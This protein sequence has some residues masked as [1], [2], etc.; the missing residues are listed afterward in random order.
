MTKRYPSH[1]TPSLTTE[2]P[3][4]HNRFLFSSTNPNET[5]RVPHL[6]HSTSFCTTE[7]TPLFVTVN[8]HYPQCN[9]VWMDWKCYSRTLIPGLLHCSYNSIYPEQ[10]EY[11]LE[12]K[13]LFETNEHKGHALIEMPTGTGKT[14]CIFSV[15][16]ASRFANPR[17]G[18]AS[19]LMYNEIGKLV[20]CT[21]TIAEL[22][23]C[24]Q[25]LKRV[26]AYRRAVLG[27]K[28]IPTN[29]VCLSSRRNLCIHSSIDVK[30]ADVT[31]DISTS[32]PHSVPSFCRMRATARFA[33]P[34]RS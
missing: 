27:N 16:L 4:T 31:V 8:T 34:R 26:A 20:Y 5:P 9:S 29:G 19:H 24:M 11:M 32:I 12:L 10:Y 21:R 30:N 1:H 7:I 23:Q 17:M 33:I 3:Q 2:Y 13:Q 15:Y 6:F 22:N 18:S 25:E 14:V 28:Y